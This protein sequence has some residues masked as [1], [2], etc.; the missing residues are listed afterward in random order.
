MT[1]KLLLVISLILF[2]WGLS[3]QENCKEYYFSMGMKDEVKV[4]KYID[5]N[6]PKNIEYWKV[7]TNPLT[8]RIL[9]ESYLADF[10]IYNSFE[11]V[12]T[13]DGAELIIYTDYE[14]NNEGENTPI[15]AEIVDKDVYKWD[16]NGIYKYSVKY[17]SPKYGNEQ[18]TKERSKIR[19][20]EISINGT[21]YSVLKFLDN[22]EVKS[23]DGDGGYTFHQLTYYAKGI[24]MVKYERYL[25]D[26][27]IV[28]LEL[29]QILS[30]EE[31]ENL[32]NKG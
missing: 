23:L 18:F 19:L 32:K 6:D 10:T 9:T 30:E 7:T 29:S 14:K 4:F 5:K 2:I 15:E 1:K 25:P 31:F 11:E 3:A 17:Q 16:D 21:E 27:T 8:N 12:I 24:G 26:G 20:T 28:E 22:Y 13:N